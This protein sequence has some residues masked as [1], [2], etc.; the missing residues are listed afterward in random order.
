[1]QSGGKTSRKQDHRVNP[2]NFRFP[3]RD[4]CTW[5]M[6][7]LVPGRSLNN[8]TRARAAQ[9]QLRLSGDPPA[10]ECSDSQDVACGWR[11]LFRA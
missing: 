7:R 8:E 6:E 1:M 10:D 9:R 11:N 5:Q 2:K 3:N 4:P